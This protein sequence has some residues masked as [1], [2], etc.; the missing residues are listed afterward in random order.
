MC[1][2]TCTFLLPNK[3]QS[4]NY[5]KSKFSKELRYL[6]LNMVCIKKMC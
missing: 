2:E 3:K 6:C 1:M 4:V 5:K